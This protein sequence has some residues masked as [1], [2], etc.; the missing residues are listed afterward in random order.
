M[1]HIYREEEFTRRKGT[2]DQSSKAVKDN[3]GKQGYHFRRTRLRD[4]ESPGRSG[5]QL[6]LLDNHNNRF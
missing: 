6:D 4:P 3:E 5:G 2:T 1:A